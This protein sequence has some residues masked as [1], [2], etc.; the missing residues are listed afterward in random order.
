MCVVYFSFFESLD[1]NVTGSSSGRFLPQIDY[2]G[3]KATIR[4]A[5][6]PTVL[7]DD[8][9][10]YDIYI[11]YACTVCS[12]TTISPCYHW[13]IENTTL[14]YQLSSV[15]P[16]TMYTVKISASVLNRRKKLT[17]NFSTPV[18]RK[19]VV[20]FRFLFFTLILNCTAH[21]NVCECNKDERE[22]DFSFVYDEKECSGWSNVSFNTSWCSTKPDA[23]Q[24]TLEWSSSICPGKSNKGSR[25]RSSDL[26]FSRFILI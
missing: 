6:P 25:S 16:S 5:G 10:S 8:D 23:I 17:S 13:N 20:Q 18:Q 14:P 7:R 26:F 3:M 1:S 19:G 15:T 2:D 21:S 24:T 11:L 12:N 4:W 22:C 9:E